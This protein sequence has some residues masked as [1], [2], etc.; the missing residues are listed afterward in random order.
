MTLTTPAL[1][2]RAIDTMN[3]GDGDELATLFAPVGTVLHESHRHEGLRA[4]AAWFARI[5]PVVIRPVRHEHDGAEHVV[6]AEV[7][8]TSPHGPELHRF[9]FVVAEHQ[10]RSMSVN[11]LR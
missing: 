2:D 8:G 6:D 5:P 9:R 1:V 4:I 7:E 11:V 10:I 3:S